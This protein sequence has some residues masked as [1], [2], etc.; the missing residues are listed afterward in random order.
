MAFAVKENVRFALNV[1]PMTNQSIYPD[2]YHVHHS[3]YAE[4]IPFWLSLANECAGAILELG[5][6]SGRVLTRLAEAG[7]KVYGI[8]LDAGMLSVLQRLLSPDL[9]NSVRLIQADFTRFRLERRFGLILLPCNTYSTLGALQ[10]L[11]LLAC[12]RRCLQAGGRF[13]FSVPNPQLL[14]HL[15]ARTEAE[16]EEVFSHPVDGEPVQVSS[17]WRRTRR[18]FV[19]TW[20]YDHLLPDGRVERLSVVV[21]H[22]L[23]EIQAYLAEL[24]NAGFGSFV[25]YGDFDFSAFTPDSPH[26]ILLARATD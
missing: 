12:V 19:L 22:E 1:W 2:L 20:R 6:G 18:Q 24:L 26:L 5:C 25:Q 15:P 14:K 8:E 7:H 21:S 17:E 4:D 16:V 10:R 13:A 9:R 11:S 3:L 23:V